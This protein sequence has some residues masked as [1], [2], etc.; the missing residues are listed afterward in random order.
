MAKDATRVFLP[1]LFLED[2]STPR[3]L[4]YLIRSLGGSPSGRMFSSLVSPIHVSAPLRAQM[5]LQLL[6]GY[7]ELSKRPPQGADH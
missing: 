5:L 1:R 2:I 3:D 6:Y 7:L 4:W